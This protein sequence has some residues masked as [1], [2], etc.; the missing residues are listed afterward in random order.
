MKY[1]EFEW[2]K[3]AIQSCTTWAQL[4]S[5]ITKLIHLFSDKYH[6]FDL[7][8]RLNNERDNHA[9]YNG[10][11]LPMRTHLNQ[12][13]PDNTRGIVYLCDFTHEPPTIKVT[14]ELLFTSSYDALEAYSNIPNPASQIVRGADK[15]S[16][17]KE[18][19]ALHANLN[20]PKWV[21][22]LTQYL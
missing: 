14:K 13:I 12:F 16:L 22:S 3:R 8:I 9:L 2:I 11:I 19:T 7:V 18:L 17:Y 21:E 20:N 10:T 4:R 15:E 5:P 6:D 1:A